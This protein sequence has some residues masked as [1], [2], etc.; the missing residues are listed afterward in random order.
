MSQSKK[1]KLLAFYPMARV[2]LHAG[3]SSS[4][5]LIIGSP[6]PDING[7]D[8]LSKC[9]VLDTDHEALWNDAF[10]HFLERVRMLIEGERQL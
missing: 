4:D 9:F 2:F 10:D 6:R 3:G 5:S 7:Y 8:C 1:E